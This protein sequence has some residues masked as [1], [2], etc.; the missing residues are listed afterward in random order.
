MLVPNPEPLR[1][2]DRLQFPNR[3]GDA[4]RVPEDASADDED[5]GAC[6]DGLCWAVLFNTRKKLIERIDPLVH[7]AADKVKR[8]PKRDLFEKGM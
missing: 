4:L 8:W 1:L 2:R 7:Q 3:R 5:I 6:A